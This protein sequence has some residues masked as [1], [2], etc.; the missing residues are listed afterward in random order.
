[1]DPRAWPWAHRAAFIQAYMVEALLISLPCVAAAARMPLANVASPPSRAPAGPT[2]QRVYVTRP[3]RIHPPHA[4]S[5]C[6]TSRWAMSGPQFGAL[7]V[8]IP[9]EA[10]GRVLDPGRHNTL[11]TPLPWFNTAHHMNRP[12]QHSISGSTP[13]NRSGVWSH[14]AGGSI[15]SDG[16]STIPRSSMTSRMVGRPRSR[17]GPPSRP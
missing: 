10:M 7:G 13:G 5:G 17:P 2:I 12:P 14:P 4:G 11:L 16:P 6:G 1:M 15:A 3:S 9:A 8:R